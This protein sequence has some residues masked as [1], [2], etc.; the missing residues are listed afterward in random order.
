M[1]FD[2]LAQLGTAAFVLG[3]T[4][5][6]Y[7]INRRAKGVKQTAE[8][9]NAVAR[10]TNAVARATADEVAVVHKFVNAQHSDSANRE[11]QL[12]TSITDAGN[13]V[14]PRLP[15]TE[16]PTTPEATP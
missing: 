3:N 1:N 2:T 13:A 9:T 16:I 10:D 5:L 8:D 7:R 4:A 11:T 14:P 6:A 12:E 15:A